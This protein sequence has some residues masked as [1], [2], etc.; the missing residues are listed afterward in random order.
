MDNP[1]IV[2]VT[3]TLFAVVAASLFES[4]RGE[5]LRN[6]RRK[7]ADAHGLVGAGFELLRFPDK[8]PEYYVHGAKVPKEEELFVLEDMKA[9]EKL[10]VQRQIEYVD[11]RHRLIPDTPEFRA[12]IRDY[13]AVLWARERTGKE[14]LART[15]AIAPYAYRRE[16]YIAA[17]RVQPPR[18]E[19]GELTFM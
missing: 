15:K 14:K 1:V 2:A 6:Y 13:E 5:N 8:M 11:Q 19:K 17:S 10:G 7:V 18:H 4:R 9:L 12:R 16:Y 3:L